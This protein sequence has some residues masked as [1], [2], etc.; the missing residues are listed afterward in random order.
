MFITDDLCR[1]GLDPASL[2]PVVQE[3]PP[4]L[5]IGGVQILHIPK[6]HILILA[7]PSKS[8]PLKTEEEN[9]LL[10][11]MASI[12]D[13]LSV[14]PFW[15]ILEL[16]PVKQCFQN[17][18]NTW[19]MWYRSNMGLGRHIPKQRKGT[20]KI[21]QS[22]KMRTEAQFLNGMK[23]VPKALFN[24]ALQLGNVVWVN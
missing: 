2:F 10:D 14:V 9:E 23:Y 7:S 24:K 19:V 15:W 13:Q 21:H 17:D 8:L 16:L 5:P 18:D 22:V 6:A 1:I 12:Y 3:C 20:V 11:A 4:A